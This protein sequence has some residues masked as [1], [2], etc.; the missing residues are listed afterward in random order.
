LS[1][2]SGLPFNLTGS[3]L[4][5]WLASVDIDIKT[6]GVFSLLT[7][8]YVL[9]FLWA[10]FLDRYLPPLLGRRRGWI[11]LF[12]LA[13]GVSLAVMGL[14]SPRSELA[15][16]GTMAF[17]VAF[18]SAS[19]DIVFDAYRVDVI[20]PAERGLAAG[21]TNFGY[22]SA[23]MF[24]G[25]LLLMVAKRTGFS[26]AY[27][28]VAVIMLLTVLATLWA[29]EPEVPGRPPRTLA[30]AVSHPLRNLLEQ[31]GAAGFLLFVLLYKV[32]DA[33]A[34][35][36]YS[37]FMLKGVG[38]T[39]DQLSWG[40]VDMTVS[41]MAGAAIGGWLYMR[42]GMFRSL[43]VFGIGQACTNLLYMW[44]AF[45]G[46]K[47]WLMLLA[48]GLDTGVGGMGQA[49][50]IAFIVSLC[51]ASY[52]ATQFALL[53]ALAAVPRTV[54]GYV[55][56][57]VVSSVGWAHFFVITFVTALPGLSLLMLLRPRINALE[58]REA[59]P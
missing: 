14:S 26:I 44:L 10:P 59:R 35:S 8:P 30:D 6:I 22:R 4:Q 45:A 50:F 33:F 16:L 28:L 2:A 19:Q 47:F 41:T 29:P 52:S 55:A 23:A 32:G 15:V 42:W 54:L 37:A 46:P 51:S 43:L 20:P 13:L 5:A 12:Q 17:V 48:T 3:T 40:K 49:A 21:A 7:A 1:F 58:A 53:S 27:L 11:M 9:K 31:S 57:T 24:G 39:L 34:L 18:L 36:L 56:A 25:A 38:F